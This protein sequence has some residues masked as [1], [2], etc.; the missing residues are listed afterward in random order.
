MFR[1][2]YQGHCITRKRLTDK[3]QRK[4]NQSPL[5]ME[6]KLIHDRGHMIQWWLK[7]QNVEPSFSLKTHCIVQHH[8]QWSNC[9]GNMKGKI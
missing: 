4:E 3:P 8:G 7:A 1:L 2:H 5:D 9:M 6:R